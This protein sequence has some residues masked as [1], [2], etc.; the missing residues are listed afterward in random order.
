MEWIT[1]NYEMIVDI[2]AKVIALAAAVAAITP[3]KFDNDLLTKVSGFINVLG[4]NI[5]KAKNL[6]DA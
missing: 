5:L 4:L 2:V 6:D 3:S 1:T